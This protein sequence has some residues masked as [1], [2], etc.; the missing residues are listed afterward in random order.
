[1]DH[2]QDRNQST[3]QEN[4]K[5]SKTGDVANIN[6]S[7]AIELDRF[8][9]ASVAERRAQTEDMEADLATGGGAGAPALAAQVD[10]PTRRTTAMKDK[11]IF[12]NKIV[13][14]S[15]FF[16]LLYVVSP[17]CIPHLD[18]DLV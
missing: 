14:L 13:W 12:T 10:T 18:E 17:S 4:S 7:S 5:E 6:G 15:A 16:L 1:M 3:K 11:E 9:N 2:E 8:D